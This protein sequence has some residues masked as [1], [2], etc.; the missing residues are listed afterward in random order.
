MTSL[1]D[2]EASGLLEGL[3]W[4]YVAPPGACP[5]GRILDGRMF[6]SLAA[7]YEVLPGFGENPA[8]ER[9]P[10]CCTALPVRAAA[11]AVHDRPPD[12]A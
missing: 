4:Q 5:V 3:S 11:A 2:A 1:D 12:A 10:C 9:R 6:G 8:C 7:V